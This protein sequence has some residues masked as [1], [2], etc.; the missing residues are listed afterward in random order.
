MS[1]AAFPALLSHFVPQP[2]NTEH[3]FALKLHVQGYRAA[4]RTRAPGGDYNIQSQE[5]VK[6]PRKIQDVTC[7][8]LLN[9]PTLH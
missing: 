9:I 3:C 5:E 4:C 8:T 1:A 2:H 7:G 6:R